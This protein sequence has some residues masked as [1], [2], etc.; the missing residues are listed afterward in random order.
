MK[1]SKTVGF[2]HSYHI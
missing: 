1:Y 2:G